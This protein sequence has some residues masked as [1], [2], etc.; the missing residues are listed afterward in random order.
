MKRS[1]VELNGL[2]TC[3]TEEWERGAK[4]WRRRVWEEKEN[5]VKIEE[6]GG[7]AK[8]ERWEVSGGKE[9]DDLEEKERGTVMMLEYGGKNIETIRTS[10]MR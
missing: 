9:N 10:D 5:D 1:K 3:K 2:L 4:A 7:G 6:W 8:P